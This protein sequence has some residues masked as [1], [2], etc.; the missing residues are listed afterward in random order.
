MIGCCDSPFEVLPYNSSQNQNSRP[1][2]SARIYGNKCVLGGFPIYSGTRSRSLEQFGIVGKSTSRTAKKMHNVQHV[3]HTV[4]GSAGNCEP[5][6]FLFFQYGP[7]FSEVQGY[8]AS[9]TPSKPYTPCAL[10]TSSL[11]EKNSLKIA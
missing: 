7:R 2:H 10:P 8:S 6:S 3:S 1:R 5:P 9:I 4:I 11:D